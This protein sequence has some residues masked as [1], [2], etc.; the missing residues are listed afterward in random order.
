MKR[1]ALALVLVLSV[2]GCGQAATVSKAPT[3]ITPTPAALWT[4]PS[5]NGQPISQAK[6]CDSYVGQVLTKA[7]ETVN[8][9]DPE[10]TGDTTYIQPASA[11]SCDNGETLIMISATVAG[12]EGQKAAKLKAG[13]S[14]DR[15]TCKV[16]ES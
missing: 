11:T 4:E 9:S 1:T 13:F 14:L 3:A 10:G 12:I 15:A 16:T 5:V 2:V 8:C 6:A 7:E